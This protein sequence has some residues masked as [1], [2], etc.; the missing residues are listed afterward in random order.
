[1]P[2]Q[3]RP[4]LSLALAAAL[5]GVALLAAGAAPRA[6][7]QP[8]VDASPTVLV[9]LGGD[10]P[11]DD[12]AIA[13]LQGQGFAATRGPLTTAFAGEEKDLRDY[14]VVVALFAGATTQSSLTAQG[15]RAL[16]RFVAKGGGLV[17]GE[18]LAR[19]GQ[20]ADLLPAVHCGANRSI[21][22]TYTRVTPNAALD[23]GV[24]PSFNLALVAPGDT[25]SCLAP[26]DEATVLYSSSNGGGRRDAAGLVAWNVGQGRVASFSTRISAGELQNASYRALFVNT[27][28]WMARTKDTTPPRIKSFDVSGAGGLVSQRQVQVSLTASDSGG[29]GL[30]SY[31]IREYGYSGDPAD[32]WA[33]DGASEGWQPFQ[34]AGTTFTWTLSAKPGVRYLQVFVADRAGNVSRAAGKAMLNYAPSQV[35]IGLDELHVYRITPGAGTPTTVRMDVLG[36]NPDLYVFGPG[37]EWRPES[38]A[39]VEL[40]SFVARAGQYQI[41]VD[42][43]TAGSYSLSLLT[44]AGAVDVPPAGGNEIQRRPRISV[45]AIEPPE[46]VESPGTLPGAPVDPGAAGLSDA[47]FLPLLRQ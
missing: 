30:G 17:T 36:G 8:A 43:H 14:D 27:V 22:T 6:V 4:R 1:M 23:A 26:R 18:W 28:A 2:N 44:G 42:G 47:I 20:I 34:Q 41:E 39:P 29:S 37:L 13:A 40:W 33:Q 25:E 31:F 21:D 16:E 45:T 35:A 12:A 7:A 11:S 24:T 9:L 10:Q 46:P 38:D 15:A 19:S 32:G 5:L 3:A